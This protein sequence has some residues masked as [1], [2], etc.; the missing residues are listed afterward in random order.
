MLAIFTYQATLKS[1][2]SK[3][4]DNFV[5]TFLDTNFY[6]DNIQGIVFTEDQLMTI[7]KDANIIVQQACHMQTCHYKSGLAISQN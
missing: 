3:Y 4:K 7:Y 6:V 1:N 2:L 5:A